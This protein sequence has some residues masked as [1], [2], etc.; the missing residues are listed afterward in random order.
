MLLHFDLPNKNERFVNLQLVDISSEITSR[1]LPLVIKLKLDCA[2]IIL[3]KNTDA[4]WTDT[5]RK[6]VEKIQKNNIT[7]KKDQY[8]KTMLFSPSIE[9]SEDGKIVVITLPN[10]CGFFTNSIFILDAL[11]IKRIHSRLFKR[12]ASSA[13]LLN[14]E[15]CSKFIP[16][17]GEKPPGDPN[18][19]YG[20]YNNTNEKVSY[21]SEERDNSAPIKTFFEDPLGQL[22]AGPVS[23]GFGR[24]QGSFVFSKTVPMSPSDTSSMLVE[25]I[26]TRLLAPIFASVNLPSLLTMSEREE[27]GDHVIVL[28]SNTDLRPLYNDVILDIT[29]STTQF[30]QRLLQWP[31]RSRDFIFRPDS[32][33]LDFISYSWKRA[34]EAFSSI[35]HYFPMIITVRNAV[36]GPNSYLST[37]GE[38]SSFCYINKEG[39]LTSSQLQVPTRVNHLELEFFDRTLAPIVFQETSFVSFHCSYESV[40]KCKTK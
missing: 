10:N 33:V 11:G 2:D 17:Y 6:F 30:G 13:D 5:V 16:F 20:L 21:R 39:E 28:G 22:A 29:I 12:V 14:D 40:K 23:S 34:A 1:E 32:A 37:I 19:F 15:V 36:G 3:T 31:S 27:T 18:I 25:N 4:L 26:N 8:E 9:L 38:T 24:M 35:S 7:A